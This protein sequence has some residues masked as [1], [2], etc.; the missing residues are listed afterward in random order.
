MESKINERKK[1]DRFDKKIFV[2]TG[3]LQTLGRSEAS[4]II[5]SYGGKVTGSVSKKTSYVLA[6]EG[7]GS[8]LI[9]AE[10]LGIEI[11]TEEEFKEMIK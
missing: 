10:S 8:K 6:G 9:K 5:Q 1:D 3:T 7:A 4:E 2:L 11:L